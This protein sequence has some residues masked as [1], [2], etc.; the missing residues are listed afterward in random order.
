MQCSQAGQCCQE[1]H[2]VTDRRSM[3]ELLELNCELRY[4]TCGRESGNARLCI[5]NGGPVPLCCHGSVASPLH[6]LPKLVIGTSVYLSIKTR[7]VW[8]AMF[9]ALDVSHVLLCS[10]SGAASFAECYP[11]APRAPRG[12]MHPIVPGRLLL[13]SL[14]NSD[15]LLCSIDERTGR[16]DAEKEQSSAGLAPAHAVLRWR[17]QNPRNSLLQHWLSRACGNNSHLSPP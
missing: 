7:Q 16:D 4:S 10:F 5:R 15:R 6:C 8:N 2:G 3:K 12:H 9:S 13:Y 17:Q 1:A 11:T 14:M